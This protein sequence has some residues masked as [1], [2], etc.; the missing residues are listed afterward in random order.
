MT[1]DYGK[2]LSWPFVAS[3]LNSQLSSITSNTGS[4]TSRLFITDSGQSNFRIDVATILPYKGNRPTEKPH[5]YQR[6]RDYL[7][8]FKK[9]EVVYGMEADDKLSI[10]QMKDRERW[11]IQFWSEAK[12]KEYAETVICSID[13]DLDMVPGWHYNWTKDNAKP[14][15][16]NETKAIQNFY[17]QLLTGDVVDNI[18][19]LY[20]VGGKSALLS[21]CR[22]YTSELDMYRHVGKHY[23]KRFGSYAEQFMLEN[24]KLLWMLRTD[25]VNEL[26][27]RFDGLSR[28]D[29]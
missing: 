1:D 6:V 20:N 29:I 25:N 28:V 7:V 26:E 5:H 11:T 23:K 17:C 19:G 3:R 18:L 24:A 12:I 22:S 27:E 21:T 14:Y 2:P 8:K 15:F 9:A 16:I 4:E 13:K 10:E